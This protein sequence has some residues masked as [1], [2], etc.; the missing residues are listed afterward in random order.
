MSLIVISLMESKCGEN[1]HIHEHAFSLAYSLGTAH[2][3][4]VMMGFQENAWYLY[5]FFAKNSPE[6]YTFYQ[7]PG[8]VFSVRGI[9]TITWIIFS[10]SK[11]L[12]PLESLESLEPLEPLALSRVLCSPNPNDSQA[13]CSGL[14]A[15]CP[16][17]LSQN[18]DL[19]FIYVTLALYIACLFDRWERT[20]KRTIAWLFLIL[21]FKKPARNN[22]EATITKRHSGLGHAILFCN[23]HLMLQWFVSICTFQRVYQLRQ[24]SKAQSFL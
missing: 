14:Y 20:Q 17:R 15:V 7:P 3:M 6:L 5:F 21:P 8:L 9:Q 1:N 4:Q 22:V 18:Y 2:V 10:I 16:S 12:E 13:L 19:T 23:F 11:S 24:G